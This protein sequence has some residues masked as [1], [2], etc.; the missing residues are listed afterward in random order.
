MFWLFLI[1]ISWLCSGL[2]QLKPVSTST[3]KI[4]SAHQIQR[5]NIICICFPQSWDL[6]FVQNMS[7]LGLIV[8]CMYTYCSNGSTVTYSSSD[9]STAIYKSCWYEYPVKVQPFLVMMMCRAQ[10]PFYFTGYEFSKCSLETFTK[11]HI[12]SEFF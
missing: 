3:N 10:K 9:F 7:N 8:S 1:G 6:M 11:V 12:H 5:F 4:H 2:F